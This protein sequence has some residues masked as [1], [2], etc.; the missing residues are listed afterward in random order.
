MGL[1]ENLRGKRVYVDTN[2]FIYLLEGNESLSVEI[3][4]MRAA[5]LSN[6]CILISSDLIYTE[7]LPPLVRSENPE[8]IRQAL[9]FLGE[10]AAFDLRSV[11]K[12]ICIQAGFLRGQTGMKTPDAIHVAS[13]IAAGCDAFLTNDDRIRLPETMQRILFSNLPA[14]E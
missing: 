5:I 3:A 9:R 4:G 11:T 6:E 8:A 2:I 7:I 12:E 1:R 13:A 14:N 10:H